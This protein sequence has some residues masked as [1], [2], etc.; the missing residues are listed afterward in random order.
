MITKSPHR[1]PLEFPPSMECILTNNEPKCIRPHVRLLRPP[2]YLT[3][4]S[5]Q[6]PTRTRIS[7]SRRLRALPDGAFPAALALGARTV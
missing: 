3:S 2:L 4:L 5:A 1:F 7:L 6:G